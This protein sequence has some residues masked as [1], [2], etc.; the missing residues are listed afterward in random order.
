MLPNPM[1]KIL[2]LILCFLSLL[3]TVLLAQQIRVEDFKRL[4]KPLLAPRPYSVDKENA[5]LDLFT[6]E[7]GFEFFLGQQPIPA[8]E[9]EGMVTLLLPDK[10]A[11]FTIRHPEYGQLKWKVPDGPLRHNKHYQAQ[12]VTDNPSKEFALSRQ[13][14]VL[15]IRPESAIVTLDST[16]HR[17]LTG[18]VQALL[19]VGRHSVRVQSPFFEEHTDT[20]ILSDTARLD[21]HVQLKPEYS[22]LEVHSQVPDA[23]I[24]LD[25]QLIGTGTAHSGRISPGTYLLSLHR[26]PRCFHRRQVTLASAQ[27]HILTIGREVEERIASGDV[28]PADSL[29]LAQGQDGGIAR[30][31]SFYVLAFD[32]STEIWVNRE[33]VGTGTWKDKLQ[34]GVYA[35]STSKDGM[36][37]RTQYVEVGGG[38]GRQRLKM[39]TP[40]ASYAW[41]NVSSNV[42]DAQV[43][44]DDKL[45]GTTPCILSPLSVSRRYRLRLVKEGYKSEELVVSLRGNDMQNIKVE[46]KKK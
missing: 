26:G 28:L 5:I 45:V 16:M 19:P 15:H 20:F 43:W 23:E 3:P 10:T 6:Q 22:Y 27:R 1:S 46:L 12:L 7:K 17:T 25:G 38:A 39:P 29:L 42:V 4:K 33:R 11:F 35:V 40:Y 2:R 44:L 18:Q 13:W 31:D 34:P 30:P 21:L 14:V 37:S 8:Q 32:D 41:L 24:R 9:G 36:E